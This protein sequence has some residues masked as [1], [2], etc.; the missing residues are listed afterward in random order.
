M[1]WS[2]LGLDPTKDKKAITAAYRAR[3]KQT[4]PED[5]PEE[6]K[7]LR[8]AYEEAIRLADQA[9]QPEERDESPLGLWKERLNALYADFAARLQP[10]NWKALLSDDVCIGLDSRPQA[11][12]ALLQFLLEKYFL[13]RNVWQ[14]IDEAFAF[15]QRVDELCEQYPREFVENAIV[16]GVQLDPA[17]PYDLFEPGVN[18]ADCDTYRRLYHQTGQSPLEELGSILDRMEALSETHPYGRAL[19]CRWQMDQG[20]REEAVA[21]FRSLARAYPDDEVL[22]LDWAAVCMESGDLEEAEATARHLLA[23]NSDHIHAKRIVADCLAAKGRLDDAKELAFEIMHTAGDDPMIMDQCARQVRQWN[24]TLIT[25]RQA[26][27]ETDPSD[28][29]NAIELAWCY[30]QNERLEDA[31]EIAEKIDPDCPDQFAYHN[32]MGKLY[33]NLKRCAEAL[34][35]LE[36]AEKLIRRMTP[37]G[38]DKTA[39]RMA[40]LPEMIQVQGNCLMQMGQEDQA[41]VKFEQALALAPE[42]PKILT[43]MGQI[44]FASG[45]Y[46]GTVGIQE[47][48]L[49]VSPG[50]WFANVILSLALQKLHRD[51]EAFDAVNRAMSVQGGDLSLYVIKMQILLRNGVF[52]EVRATLDFL[53]DNGAPADLST[54]W[55]KAQLTEL[56]EKNEKK[57]FQQYQALARRVES[58]E[59]FMDAASLYYRMAVLMGKQMDED[60]KEDRE[61][62]LTVLEKGLNQ[63]KF[64][65]DCLGY[66]AWLLRKDGRLDE[67]VAMY[68]SLRTPS[69]QLKLAELYYGD[70]NRYA[71]EALAC[72]EELLQQ[73]QSAELYFYAATCKRHMGDLEGAK[74]YYER[75][76]ELD[77]MDV[78]GYNGLAFILESRGRCEEALAEIGKAIDVM[79]ETGNV[80]LWLLEHQAQVLRRMG[81]HREALAAV[82]DALGRQNDPFLWQLKFDICCQFGLYDQAKAVL[83][84]WHQAHRNDPNQ[85]V[86]AGRLY[87]LTGKMFKASLAMGKVKHKIRFD[88]EQNFRL[89]LADLEC[90]HKRKVQLLSQ[91]T[92]HGPADSDTLGSLALAQWWSGDRDSA[93]RNAARALE[94]IDQTLEGYL[95]D[96]ALYRSRRSLLLAILGREQ[97]ARAELAAVRKL[98][99]CQFCAYGSCKDADIYEAYIEEIVGNTAQARN[100]YQAGRQNWPDELDFVS[101][102][103]RL[104]KKGK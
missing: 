90:N 79:W 63:D 50:S 47:Q 62:L 94:L 23:A 89:Q 33:H 10:E 58:G 98:P 104:K 53:R 48:L 44:L 29:D 83:D 49:R 3:L 27:M 93:V 100:L 60:R 102:E 18:G 45:D 36:A 38:T 24:E 82:D 35:H 25:Q 61:I 68:R 66:K 86:A 42:D 103:L 40:R 70:L 31:M 28:W 99:L 17:L 64:H 41:R 76:L 72:Y 51:R 95:V 81:R 43:I 13:P 26:A 15:S 14:V 32:L 34:P 52:D 12:E 57:A 55:I 92:I 101:G 5:K 30:T 19:R 88:Q 21:G 69:A 46:E 59:D 80:F 4:N 65:E 74:R 16:N 7:A 91:Q 97:E 9:D 37:D 71:A 73:R 1:D 96:E 56:E 8:A 85:A 11:E 78:D 20:L 22:N 6:F 84:Q 54:D 2:I 39:K 75:E 87:L 77:P 67:A